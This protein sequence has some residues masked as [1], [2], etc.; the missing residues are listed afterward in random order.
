MGTSSASREVQVLDS[1]CALYRF[2]A[3]LQPRPRSH[4]FSFWQ[5]STSTSCHALHYAQPACVSCLLWS[6]NK[7]TLKRLLLRELFIRSNLLYC[8]FWPYWLHKI[9][10]LLWDSNLLL[11]Y[12]PLLRPK[13]HYTQ[14]QN[15][16]S[17]KDFGS[18]SLTHANTVALTP[19]PKLHY[20]ACL[21]LF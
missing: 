21:L 7:A 15:S 8:V 17:M 5:R 18:L 10:N 6:S 1:S 19:P 16:H 14:K 9:M 12:I 3:D 13:T 4:L 2:C 11:L 20:T